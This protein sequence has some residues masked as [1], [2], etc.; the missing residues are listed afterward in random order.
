MVVV[1]NVLARSLEKGPTTVAP[2]LELTCH[3]VMVVVVGVIGKALDR[4]AVPRA[5][6][7]S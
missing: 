4:L 1:E 3:V 5:R 2:S 7:L 6:H